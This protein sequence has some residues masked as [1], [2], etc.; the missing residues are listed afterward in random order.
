[1]LHEIPK[2]SGARTDLQPCQPDL[3]RLKPK[4]DVLRENNNPFHEIR[5]DAKLVKPKIK[6]A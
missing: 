3:K 5:T 4:A 1:M 6:A 2:A